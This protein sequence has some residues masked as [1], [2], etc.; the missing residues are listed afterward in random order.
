MARQEPNQRGFIPP[1]AQQMQQQQRTQ[2]QQPQQPPQYYPPQQQGWPGQM[3]PGYQGQAPFAGRQGYVMP[4][5]PP[6]KP[7]KQ[8]PK[9]S[10]KWALVAVI[11]LAAVLAVGAIAALSQGGGNPDPGVTAVSTQAAGQAAPEQSA[12]PQLSAEEIT[13]RVTACDTVFCP[14]VYVNGISLG[15]MTPQE[16]ISAVNNQVRDSQWTTQLVFGE[17]VKTITADMLGYT[18]DTAA[19]LS[20]AWN[21]GHTGSIEQRWQDM[22]RLEQEP[23]N[24]GT[25]AAQSSGDTSGIDSLLTMIK[26]DVDRAPQDAQMYVAN[27]QDIDNPFMFVDEVYGQSLDIFSLRQDLY[28]RAAADQTGTLDITPYFQRIEPTVHKLDLM[29]QF[30]VRATA[31]TP[32]AHNSQEG[33]NYNIQHAFDYI[34]GTRIE[35]GKTFSFN[36]VVGLR[37]PERGFQEAPEIVS[38]EL[39]DGNYGGG[40]CQVSTTIYQAAEKALLKIGTRNPHSEKVSYSELGLDATVYLTKKRNK[41]FTFTNTSGSDIYIFGTVEKDPTAKKNKKTAKRV[42]VVIY[43]VDVGAVYDLEARI[44]QEYD[45]PDKPTYVKDRTGEHLY[46]GDPP[47]L[48]DEAEKGYKV[49]AYLV[50]K[51]TGEWIYLHTDEYP[52]KAA[53]YWEG[54]KSR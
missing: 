25:G 27:P 33:R 16:A 32:I 15:G 29:Q 9:G 24:A 48:K 40:V 41:D 10:N 23:Y 14:G 8:E 21:I 4:P 28:E 5:H 34:N 18:T 1:Q 53:V 20:E 47:V 54:T 35:A 17:K 43:G 38:G 6:A 46:K 26:N 45:P 12:V 11:A 22:Q 52:A 19:A 31:T 49:E 7:Q 50:N 36:K 13:A 2:P 51:S 37:S 30:K 39:V 42:R 3:P 44:V